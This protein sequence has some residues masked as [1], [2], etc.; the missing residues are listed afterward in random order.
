MVPTKL[1]DIGLYNNVFGLNDYVSDKTYNKVTSIWYKVNY[2]EYNMSTNEKTQRSY[3][4]KTFQ[5]FNP[6]ESVD[7]YETTDLA[8]P[9]ITAVNVKTTTP[10]NIEKYVEWTG[11]TFYDKNDVSV[12]DGQGLDNGLS[13][14][15]KA[16]Q[17]DI[18]K[19]NITTLS[20]NKQNGYV[21][22][23]PDYS[24]IYKLFNDNT[25]VI[26][27]GR[28]PTDT[29][30]VYIYFSVSKP[31]ILKKYSIRADNQPSAWESPCR[32]S[33]QASNDKSNWENIDK[34]DDYTTEA[35]AWVANNQ[36]RTFSLNSNYT[37]YVY[38]R[39]EIM[40]ARKSNGSS[41]ELGGVRFY[42]NEVNIDP[43]EISEPKQI[44]KKKF[45]YKNES[46]EYTENNKPGSVEYT[47]IDNTVLSDQ[48]SVL[49]YN[50]INAT[51]EY[52]IGYNIENKDYITKHE[53]DQL[54]AILDGIGECLSKK[55]GWFSTNDKC[56]FSCQVKCQNTCQ[57]S[58]QLCNTKQ[59]HDQKCG[60]H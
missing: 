43:L 58:C 52:D 8:V 34:H 26:S 30:P 50:T 51:K 32:W 35:K 54:E 56:N 4:T 24:N 36:R 5:K 42:W 18:L 38:Y 19:S 3:W 1:N 28:R 29:K 9:T 23:C 10:E 44:G 17:S 33:L 27:F 37:P 12:V 40:E 22:S 25:N 45:F 55:D 21:L 41:L 39:L 46:G 59:C 20:S 14:I 2:I 16:G 53:Y 57:V 31:I 60:T 48:S 13:E 6:N 47:K 49:P 7:L 15:V 11:E